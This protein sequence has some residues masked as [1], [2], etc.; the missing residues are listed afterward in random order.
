M[1][2]STDKLVGLRNMF[3]ADGSPVRF[4]R[5]FQRADADSIVYQLAVLLDLVLGAAEGVR[6]ACAYNSMASS[7]Y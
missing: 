4:L 1:R 3:Q 7:T 2:G 5:N 6:K